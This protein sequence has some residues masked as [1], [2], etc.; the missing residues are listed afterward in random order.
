MHK[1]SK[2]II[3]AYKI[4]IISKMKDEKQNGTQK[5]L[6]LFLVST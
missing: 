5:S 4:L 6:T 3:N 2:N 1:Y